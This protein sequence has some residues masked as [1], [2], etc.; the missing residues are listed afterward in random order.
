MVQLMPVVSDPPA[1]RVV[2]HNHNEI[3]AQAMNAIRRLAEV[4]QARMA[5]VTHQGQTVARAEVLNELADK[6]EKNEFVLAVVGEFSRGKS[7]LINALLGYPDLLPTSIEPTTAAITLISYGET[8]TAS[9]VFADGTVKE[10]I[11]LEELRAYVRGANLDGS[12]LKTRLTQRVQ[13][14]QRE[15][16]LH[17][18]SYEDLSREAQAQL[19][20]TVSGRR[21]KEVRLTLPSPFL[22]DGIC[23]VDTPGIGSVNPEHGEATRHFVHRAD[24]VIF[25]INTD[26]VISASECNF[27]AFLRDH[28][29]RFLFAVTKIDRFTEEER[30][31]SLAYTWQT[32]VNFADIQNP[33]IFPISARLALEGRQENNPAKL[34]QSGFPAFVRALDV[35]LVRERGQAFVREQVAHA[36]RHL[37]DLRNAVEMEWEGLT[38][39]LEELQQRIAATRPELEKAR[40]AYQDIL[41]SLERTTQDILR[42][43]E[44]PAGINFM[45]L[46]MRLQE[47]VLK[48]VD[49]YDWKQLRHA[50]E[51]IPLFVRDRL[52][53]EL[54]QKLS[55]ITDRVLQLRIDVLSQCRS[56][57]S[58]MSQNVGLHF[59]SLRTPREMDI[60]FDFDTNAFYDELKKVS[61]ITIGSTLALTIASVALFGGMGAVVMLGGLLAGTTL[62]PV[63]R[64]RV[65][66]QLKRELPKPLSE[67]SHTL[68]QN[69]KAE[70]LQH[71]QQFQTDVSRML[72]SA[73]SSVEDTLTQ[74]EKEASSTE[75]N[76]AERRATLAAQRETLAQI[77]DELTLLI[78]PG[79]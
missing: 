46:S 1:E 67:L 6:L 18:L 55:E 20:R 61:T 69:I 30:E 26:P 64:H 53:Q 54:G 73:M 75:F 36:L 58:E 33:P 4:A 38:V 22:K 62:T 63:L 79:W 60:E 23:L 32:I 66:Q 34:A 40:Q 74:L 14:A 17:Q 24:A 57:V 10:D 50:S 9:V 35:F 29:R 21:V 76:T 68:L 5:T 2:M 56:I 16:R 13:Q 11:S 7:T 48:Q 72:D 39:P 45:R 78:G 77:E 52:T 49:E 71:L 59:R 15:N 3:R 65:R 70:V 51:L 31:Q 28:V 8:P 25:L 47:D 27:L 12:D 42:S 37:T 44:G 43:L 19:H 41:R